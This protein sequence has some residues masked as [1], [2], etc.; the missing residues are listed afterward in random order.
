MRAAMTWLILV[1]VCGGVARAAS[2]APPQDLDVHNE[3][4]IIPTMDDTWNHQDRGALPWQAGPP[5]AGAISQKAVSSPRKAAAAD[6][7]KARRRVPGG[8]TGVLA[9]DPDAVWLPRLPQPWAAL[10]IALGG[11]ALVLAPALLA[12][13]WMR[14]SRARQANRADCFCHRPPSQP[15]VLAAR[16][17]QTQLH[18]TPAESAHHQERET[19]KTRRA[20]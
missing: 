19:D 6:S 10:L 13:R 3:G 16:L 20:A 2:G 7:A 9:S 11:L 1:F 12:G 14:A 18:G 17:V 4:L 15:A 8:R 5:I